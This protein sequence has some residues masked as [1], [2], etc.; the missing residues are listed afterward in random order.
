MKTPV[1]YL[2][3]LGNTVVNTLPTVLCNL[4]TKDVQ[5]LLTSS[6]GPSEPGAG[7][8]GAITPPYIL[9]DILTLFQPEGQITY[10][11][12]HITTCPPS[13]FQTFLRPWLDAT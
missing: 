8:E 11:L 5:E 6:T 2:S 10:V 13:D 7:G 9:S 1:H 4:L 12:H 3:C